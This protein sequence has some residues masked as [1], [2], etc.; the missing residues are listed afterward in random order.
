MLLDQAAD[1]AFIQTLLACRPDLGSPEHATLL[2]DIASA[3]RAH[4][5]GQEV[6]QQ[7]AY[8]ES[9]DWLR[10]RPDDRPF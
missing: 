9:M 6:E 8:L 2:T 10:S 4:E 7:L 5:K 3:F 1:Q